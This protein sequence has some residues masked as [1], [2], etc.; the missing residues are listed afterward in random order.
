MFYFSV[1][2]GIPSIPVLVP[3]PDSGIP[4]F[5]TYWLRSPLRQIIKMS[6]DVAELVRDKVLSFC[7]RTV[8][9]VIRDINVK[10]TRPVTSG[11][12]FSF[13]RKNYYF[14]LNVWN[15]TAAMNPRQF[16]LFL[17]FYFYAL[18][19]NAANDAQRVI[20]LSSLIQIR[21]PQAQLLL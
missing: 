21:V 16:A 14:P 4:Y 20:L 10:E 6:E 7:G 8:E 5:P 11:A 17:G 2:Q 18:Y 12:F 15:R 19:V 13:H 1:I 9:T 3:V